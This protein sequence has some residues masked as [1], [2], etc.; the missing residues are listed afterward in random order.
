MYLVTSQWPTLWWARIISRQAIWC[1]MTFSIKT[2]VIIYLFAITWSYFRIKYNHRIKSNSNTNKY[3]DQWLNDSKPKPNTTDL[4]KRLPFELWSIQEFSNQ[5]APPW[6]RKIPSHDRPKGSP[7]KA[8]TTFGRNSYIFN[9]ITKK[10]VK[11]TFQ[12]H[13]PQLQ[14]SI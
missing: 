10:T 8:N 11:L 4:S 1:A 3:T 7:L 9:F 2:I 6:G 13:C 14:G 5:R 12:I